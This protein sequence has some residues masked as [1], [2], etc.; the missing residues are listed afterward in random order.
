MQLVHLRSR[1]ADFISSRLVKKSVLEI[2]MRDLLCSAVLATLLA[3]AGLAASPAA[4]QPLCQGVVTQVDA[5][6]RASLAKGA[7]G[8]V[9]AASAPGYEPLIRSYGL[10]DLEARAALRSDSVFKIASLTKQFTAAAVL[11]LAEEGK[12][13]LDRSARTYLPQYD[14]MGEVT[15]RQL[16]VQTSGLPDYAQTLASGGTKAAARTPAQ[17]AAVIGDLAPSKAFQ[18]G[19]RWEY[20]NSNYVLLGLLIEQV[21]GQSFEAFL[22]RRVL[23]PAG[24]GASGVDHPADI[25]PGRVRGYSRAEDEGRTLRNADWID[26]SIPGPAGALRS[27][28][29]DLL[30]WSKALFDGRVIGSASLAQMTAPGRLADGRTT[31]LG[32]PQAWQDGLKAD[33]AMGLFRAQSP[34]GPKLWHSGDIEGFSTWMAHYPERKITL[35]IL[36][37]ADF[38]D[39]DSDR[40]EAI[41]AAPDVCASAP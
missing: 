41:F 34:L 6:G 23:Q 27:T 11:A 14:W 19:E 4:A 32:M 12:L 10:A 18:A 7:P 38:V 36:T 20:S 15:V 30:A 16:L 3:A 8:M 35:V 17:M 37:N 28:A 31:R 5:A 2:R 25:V 9:I 40:L 21:S 29:G 22:E 1:A 24:M 33:Y 26:P 13:D 39:L